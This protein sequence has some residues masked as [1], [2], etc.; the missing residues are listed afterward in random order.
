MNAL[1]R[2]ASGPENC[3]G[4]VIQVAGRSTG[5]PPFLLVAPVRLGL[6]QKRAFV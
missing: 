2:E 5:E 3:T 4:E 1:L 6:I